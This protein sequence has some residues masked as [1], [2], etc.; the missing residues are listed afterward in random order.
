MPNSPYLA[1]VSRL[2][3]AAN[4]IEELTTNS[5]AAEV[6]QRLAEFREVLWDLMSVSLDADSYKRVWWIIAKDAKTDLVGFL[7]G[8]ESALSRLKQKVQMAITL[9]P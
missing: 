1:C 3:F 4:R 7:E 5:Q 8:D 2:L 6:T 9:L